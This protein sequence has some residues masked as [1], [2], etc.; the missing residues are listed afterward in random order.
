MP[1]MLVSTNSCR[2]MSLDVRLVECGRVQDSLHAA[3]TSV[4]ESAV[5]YGSHEVCEGRGLY[6]QTHGLVIGAGE[7]SHECFAKMTRTASDQY[8]HDRLR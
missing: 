4:N 7:S 6:I 1:L 8:L 3:H 2:R 5:S